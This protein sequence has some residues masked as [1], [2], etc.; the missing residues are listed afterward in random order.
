MI[1]RKLL[2]IDGGGIRGMIALRVLAKIESTLRLKFNSPDL[3]LADYFDFIGGTSTGGIIAAA[4]SIGMTVS[5]I[6]SFYRKQA[7]RIFSPTKNPIKHWLYA[8]YDASALTDEIKYVFGSDTTLGSE[9]LKSLLML[10]MMNGSTA[11]PWP[12]TNNPYAKYNNPIYG[13]ENNLNLPLWQ[14]VRASTAA[15]YFFEPEEISIG[16]SKY[17]FYD[18]AL[19][20][21]NNPAF[22]LFQMATLPAYGLGWQ[23]GSD[24][25]LL[26]SVGTGQIPKEIERLRLID[27]QI[28]SV[29]AS[30]M[31][32]LMFAGGEEVDIQCRCFA[33][34][35]AGLPID[36]EVGDFIAT[37]T[38]GSPH[39]SY[40]RF[41]AILNQKGLSTFGCENLLSKTNFRLD[42]IDSLEAC[43]S[44]GNAIA[45][46]MVHLEL[47]SNFNELK[48]T[49]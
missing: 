34:V 38:I 26:V 44:V 1:K 41:N 19:T 30:A 9:K 7:S 40:M 6:E 28:G 24:R 2:A 49:T 5:E 47:F 15:P 27:K 31:Q 32:N 23:T 36:S 3:V 42:D 13:A 35:L 21:L 22:K 33:N 10:V 29:L 39:Y 4:L 8:K 20:S 12:I 25:M 37:P 46:Q 43:A 14:L 11:S 16:K 45:D 17:L 18:G 48:A